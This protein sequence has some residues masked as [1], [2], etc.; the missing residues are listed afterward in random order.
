MHLASPLSAI[1]SAVIFNAL[2]IIAL[3]PLALKGVAYRPIGAAAMLRRN[4]FIYGLGGIIIPFI[5]IKISSRGPRPRAR[6]TMR[7]ARG[8]PTTARPARSLT[9]ASRPPSPPTGRRTGWPRTPGPR[10]RRDLLGERP[11]PPHQRGER[12]SPGPAGRKGPRTAGRRVKALLRRTSRARPRAIRGARRKRAPPKHRP[13]PCKRSFGFRREMRP[14]R[15]LRVCPGFPS[16]PALAPQ[17]DD[18]A[19]PRSRRPARLA[20]PRGG[21]RAG[22]S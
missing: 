17:P 1:L 11:R 20:Q 3:I 4:L 13:R 6:A 22:A 12:A 14:A 19:T 7:R 8:A 16:G 15:S 18:R 9:T 2:I 21:A 10:R 5:G